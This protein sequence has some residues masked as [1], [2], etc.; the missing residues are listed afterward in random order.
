MIDAACI[1]FTILYLAEAGIFLIC[2]S[3]L[4]IVMATIGHAGPDCV[5]TN[6]LFVATI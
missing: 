1:I 2:Q 4:A 5:D 3:G 6:F